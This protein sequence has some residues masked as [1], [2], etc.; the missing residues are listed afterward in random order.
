M[1]L[2][3]K[4]Q[5]VDGRINLIVLILGISFVYQFFNELRFLL[6]LLIDVL[7]G[8]NP[9]LLLY[10]VPLFLIP[11]AAFLFWKRKK[12]GWF[13]L[14]IVSIC[15]TVN[16]TLGFVA[17]LSSSYSGEL[18]KLFPQ[19]VFYLITIALFGGILWLINQSDIRGAFQVDK[20]TALVTIGITTLLISVIVFAI[21]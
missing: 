20:R 3:F 9:S 12:S 2:K 17:S 7:G 14:D 5:T 10:F 11:I 4:S 15:M 18:G 6:F 1:N 16:A 21:L 19:S 8:G 13:L